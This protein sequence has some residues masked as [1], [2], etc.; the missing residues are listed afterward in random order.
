[1]SLDGFIA[2]TNDQAG[3]LFD[4]YGNGAVEVTGADSGL[5]FHTSAA[6]AAYLRAA[7]ATHR[8]RCDWPAPVRP[9]QR[10]ERPPSRRRGGVR[11]D[12]QPPSDWPYPDTP[13]TFVTDGLPSALA[14]AQA[15]AGDRD[16][17]ITA[18]NIAGQVFE[19]GLIDEVRIDLVSAVFGAGI[20][21]FGDYAGSLF[22]L[23]DPQIVQGDGVTHL[24]TAC[25]GPD[26]AARA[27]A[28]GPPHATS[29]RHRC[30]RR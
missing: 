22:L 6:S 8:C 13:F 18:G 16:V 14:Q 27:S 9:G 30:I 7:W 3:P 19:A 20:R 23:D 17:S 26:I 25:E 11:S 4:W 28:G 10:L 2:G 1:M 5:V 24:H 29:R 12:L 21:F 15:V